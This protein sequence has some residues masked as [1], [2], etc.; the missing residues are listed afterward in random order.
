[1]TR[2]RI[3]EK[4]KQFSNLYLPLPIMFSHVDSLSDFKNGI[5]VGWL[6]YL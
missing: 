6:P 5:S 3:D 4:L 1:M 2:I